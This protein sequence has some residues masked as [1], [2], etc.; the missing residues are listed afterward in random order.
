MFDFAQLIFILSCN[1]KKNELDKNKKFQTDSFLSVNILGKWGGLGE[2]S[3]VRDIRKDSIYYFQHSKAYAYK[4]INKNIIIQFEN[5]SAVLKNIKVNNDTLFLLTMQ[6]YLL[7][8]IDL[9]NISFP[10]TSP[11]RDVVY[12]EFRI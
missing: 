10:A 7:K 4:V 3:P 12:P 8:D 5:S 9:N 2:A 6:E 11:V 1:T